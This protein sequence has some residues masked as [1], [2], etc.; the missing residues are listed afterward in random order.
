[1]IVMHLSCFQILLKNSKARRSFITKGYLKMIQ[2]LKPEI[3]SDLCRTI[4]AMN[5]CFPKDII[6]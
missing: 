2:N 3:D 5:C 6:K 1:M 4:K